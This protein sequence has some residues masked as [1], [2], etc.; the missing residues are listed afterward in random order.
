MNEL[1][2]YRNNPLDSRQIRTFL[3]LAQVG[4]FTKVAKKLSLTQSAVSHAMKALEEDLGC[5]LLDRVGKN[6]LLTQAG[7][8]FHERAEKIFSEMVS[9]RSEMNKLVE[10]GH[11]RLRLG[12]TAA[13]CEYILPPILREFQKE[14]PKCHLTINPGNSPDIM[15]SLRNNKIDVGMSWVATPDSNVQFIPLFDD[16]LVFMV[17]PDHPWAKVGRI[18]R[19]EVSHQQYILF[20]SSTSWNQSQSSSPAF[21]DYSDIYE[22][23]EKFFNKEKVVIKSVIDV[24][25]VSAI[26]E[27]V[28]LGLGITILPAWV[29][30]DALQDKSLVA[31]PL[32]RRKL[33]RQWGILYWKERSI[34]WAEDTFIRL[35]KERAVEFAARHGLRA[36]V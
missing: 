15:E 25:S 5:R 27:L 14:F 13:A 33:K 8:Q 4:S 16:E 12:A 21:S 26:K 17:S 30:Q 2:S 32:G 35:C 36:H 9:A 20:N 31:L 10:W 18:K 24:G 29:A 28:K 7:E 6:V 23:I 1:D 34:A 19:T 22:Q 11:V 3:M